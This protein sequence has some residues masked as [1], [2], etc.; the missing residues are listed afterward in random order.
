MWNNNIII[1]TIRR[2]VAVRDVMILRTYNIYNNLSVRFP[3]TV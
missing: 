1:Q 3:V 2:P